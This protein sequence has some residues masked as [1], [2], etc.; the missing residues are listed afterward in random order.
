MPR[1][2][3]TGFL[4]SMKEFHSRTEQARL[5]NLIDDVEGSGFQNPRHGAGQRFP[6]FG[7]FIT[8]VEKSSECV[9]AIVRHNDRR[10]RRDWR[11]QNEER[12][13]WISDAYHVGPIS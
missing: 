5:W 4:Q 6:R 13:E 11:C 8:H 10:R 2:T 12:L 1:Q 9:H 3:F 7:P